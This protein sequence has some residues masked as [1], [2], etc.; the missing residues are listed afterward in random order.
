MGLFAYVMTMFSSVGSVMVIS[1]S[2]S[3]DN[4]VG[5]TGVRSSACAV[6]PGLN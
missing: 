4:R 6:H 1:D 5:P 2:D 3:A